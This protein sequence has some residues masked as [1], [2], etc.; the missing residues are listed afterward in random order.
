MKRMLSQ[1]LIALAA[2]G[3]LVL[4]VSLPAVVLLAGPAGHAAQAPAADKA[5]MDRFDMYMTNT[6]SDALNGVLEVEK[7]YWLQ[8]AD[9][10]APRPDPACSGV[11]GSAQELLPV[12]QSAQKLL[13][14]QPLAFDPQGTLSPG[15]KVH[16][17]LDET[18]LCITWKKPIGGAMYTFSEVKIAHPSQ[19]R[20]FLADGTYGSERQYYTTDMAATVNAVA[21]SNGD[22]YKYR[23]YGIV[24]YNGVTYRAGGQWDNRLDSCFV[25]AQGELLFARAGQLPTREAVEHFVEETG[26]R[27]SVS[28]GPIL[29]ENGKNVVPEDYLIGEVDGNF[30]RSAIAQLDELHYLMV[31]T[32]YEGGWETMPTLSDFANVLV[33]MGAR[34]AYNMDGGQTAALVTC[35]QLI[36]RPNY[37]YQR[38][39]SDII[40]FATAVPDG[41]T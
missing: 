27:F 28:F 3:A 41:E 5:L 14:G 12:I 25:D 6:R 35:G 23:P 39:A 11:A 18:I 30:S 40:Y 36:N 20:R 34:K 24:V 19:F 2:A 15:T 10:V 9:M 37:G 32:S 33:D 13:D 22:F 26:A 38:T 1:I 29:V 17:Y 4:L 8:D 31:V 21:A 7:V 16:W